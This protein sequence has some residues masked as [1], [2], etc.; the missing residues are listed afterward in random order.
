MASASCRSRGP[1]TRVSEV[2][3]TERSLAHP[4]TEPITEA[5]LDQRVLRGRRLF[6]EHSSAFIWK[7]GTWFVPS[8]NGVGYYSV[9]LGRAEVCECRDFNHRGGPCKHVHA[10]AIA[11]AKS[12]T[13]SCCGHRVLNR[14]LTEVEDWHE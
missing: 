6:R 2:L 5:E 9:R 10:A 13:C 7:R 1:A 12:G 11:H 8:E 3:M 14:F 4:S